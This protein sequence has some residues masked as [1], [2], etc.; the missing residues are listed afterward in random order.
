MKDVRITEKIK[1]LL[2]LKMTWININKYHVEK[3]IFLD[4]NN[5]FVHPANSQILNS[6]LVEIGKW[7]V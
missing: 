2:K 3:N 5:L 7:I 4:S 1:P 6:F